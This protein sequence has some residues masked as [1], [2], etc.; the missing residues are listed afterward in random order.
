M[1]QK[2]ECQSCSKS[3]HNHEVVGSTKISGCCNDAHNHR[4]AA[5]TGN[6][7]PFAG[8]HIH[9]VAF[10]T[11]TCEGHH[12]EFCGKTDPAIYIGSGHHVHLVKA[13]TSA[14]A[15]HQ[16]S[17]AASVLLEDPLCKYRKLSTGN[18]SATKV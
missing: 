17:F 13:S 7:I 8:S 16:H 12:H 3:Q 4:F 1:N 18:I 11:D 6:A 9:Q 5:I 2:S 10:T 15:G 14:A